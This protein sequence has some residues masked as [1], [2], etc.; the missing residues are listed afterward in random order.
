[1]NKYLKNKKNLKMPTIVMQIHAETAVCAWRSGMRISVCVT[2]RLPPTREN[3]AKKV[4]FFIYGFK[5]N[6]MS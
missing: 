5:F 4:Y 6:K 3:N 1:M 2:A